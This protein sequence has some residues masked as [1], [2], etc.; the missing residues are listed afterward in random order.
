MLCDQIISLD[1]P[2]LSTQQSVAEGLLVFEDHH[3]QYLPLLKDGTLVGLVSQAQLSDLDERESLDTVQVKQLSVH[4]TQHI[5]A[6]L[7]AVMIAATD[8]V[9]VTDSQGAYLGAITAGGL[10]Q[11]L[12][13][14]MDIKPGTAYFNGA[15]ITLQ[16]KRQDYSFSQ[17]AR[18]IE[19]GDANITQLNTYSDPQTEAFWV[20]IRLD[21]ME[22]S[23]IISTLQRYE[24]NVVHFWGN[25]IYENELRRNYEALMNY[26]NI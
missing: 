24:Y 18:I 26:L 25:E 5:Y 17:L 15:I 19:S 12:A 14:L 2:T 9:T 13:I 8:L 16:M 1:I 21:R 11:A 10:L 22:I 4:N 20:N 6:A 23:D 3:L 7:Q